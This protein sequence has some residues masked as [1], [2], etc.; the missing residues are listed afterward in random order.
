MTPDLK[1]KIW[2]P[3]LLRRAETSGAFACIV[4]KGDPDGGAALVKVRTP[5]GQAMLY[6]PVR[7]MDGARVWWPKGPHPEGVIDL[8]MNQRLDDDP[9][10]W[11][12]EIEDREGRH[13]LTEGVE[14]E[15]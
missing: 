7:N 2:I 13:F 3:A 14:I 10:L 4:R 1:A 15:G 8:Y 11:I 6:R 12:I 5:D 9:D